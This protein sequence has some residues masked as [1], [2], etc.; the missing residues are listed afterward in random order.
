MLPVSRRVQWQYRFPDNL[1]GH[2]DGLGSRRNQYRRIQQLLAGG[3]LLIVV[4]YATLTVAVLKEKT[5]R[6]AAHQGT[7]LYIDK[8]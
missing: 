7:L 4:K 5:V 2:R 6:C 3:A 8:I 1:C